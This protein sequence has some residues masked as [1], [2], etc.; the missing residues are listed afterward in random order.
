MRLLR[1]MTCRTLEELPDPPRGVD[2]NA[3][4]PGQDPL[5]DE[6]LARH[7]DNQ[8]CQ[9]R[10]GQLFSVNDADWRDE[11]KR[12]EILT[13]MGIETTG[14]PGEFYDLKNT[15]QEDALKCFAQH[16]R[17]QGYCIDWCADSKSLGRATPE[18]KA[19]QKKN[20]DAPTMHLCH[21]CP[22]ATTVAVAKRHAAG[23]YN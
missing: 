19:W 4:E 1:C 15:F 12:N 5:L 18:G 14:L 22:V 11:K 8:A 20:P 13:Q 21:F 9:G 6:L 3:I 10:N 23:Q 2:P 7:N 16:N 17:P